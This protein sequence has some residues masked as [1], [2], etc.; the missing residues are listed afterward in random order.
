MRHLVPCIS[1][2]DLLD[3]QS[4]YQRESEDLWGLYQ[5][6]SDWLQCFTFSRELTEFPLETRQKHSSRSY[7]YTP[8]DKN[9]TPNTGYSFSLKPEL[10]REIEALIELELLYENTEDLSTEE[11]LQ[12]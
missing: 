3:A 9:G 6:S 7:T 5:D 2:T 8:F 12:S 10:V 4:K 11:L 1:S